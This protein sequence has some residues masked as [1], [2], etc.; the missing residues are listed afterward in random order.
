MTT[1]K[2]KIEQIVELVVKVLEKDEESRNNDNRLVFKV[3]TYFLDEAER[4]QQ[5]VKKSDI[6]L[7][8]SLRNIHTLPAFST[9]IRARAMIQNKLNMYLPTS[10]EIRQRRRISEDQWHEYLTGTKKFPQIK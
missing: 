8:L 2:K 1:D 3:L 5:F 7:L 4:P 6:Q 10:K 9:I